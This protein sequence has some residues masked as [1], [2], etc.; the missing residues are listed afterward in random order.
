MTQLNIDAIL[1]NLTTREITSKNII[2]MTIDIMHHVQE[3]ITQKGQGDKKKELV[4]LVLKE[5]INKVT[6]E[7]VKTHLNTLVNTC[8]PET[9]DMIILVASGKLDLGKLTKKYLS[10]CF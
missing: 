6:D 7:N 1:E 10:C 8:V 3:F 4:I 2:S 5:L 9:I